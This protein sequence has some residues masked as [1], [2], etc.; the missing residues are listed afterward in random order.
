MISCGR[1]AFANGLQATDWRGFGPR[2]KPL[3]SRVG[4]IYP[5]ADLV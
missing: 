1:L 4:A 2:G 3:L 5:C